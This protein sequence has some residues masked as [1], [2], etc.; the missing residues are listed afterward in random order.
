M[1][2]LPPGGHP[3]DDHH[4][5]GGTG[6]TAQFLKAVGDQIGHASV[7]PAALAR[8]VVSVLPVDAAG[9]STLVDVLR[10]PLGAS[11]DDAAEAEVFQTSLGEGPCLDAAEAQA[12]IV[13]DLDEMAARW[14]LYAEELMSRTP[15]RATASIPLRTPDRAVFAALD[16]YSTSPRLRDR[17]DLAEVRDVAVAVA[18]LLSTCLDQ[19]QERESREARPN[20]YR[21]VAGRRHDVWVAIGMVMASRAGR[22]RDAL[23][24]LRTHAHTLNRSLDEV[25]NA[26]VHGRLSLGDLPSHGSDRR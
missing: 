17:L 2:A 14:S 8:A 23:S 5:T 18:A 22:R 15:Y 4:C 13:A 21:A 24:L 11:S 10:T 26:L 12:V 7:T 16:L 1:T 9:L 19:V 25:A 20:W 6:R 3:T